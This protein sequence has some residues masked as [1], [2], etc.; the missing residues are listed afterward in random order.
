MPEQ[1]LR[2]A[3]AMVKSLNVPYQ[4][5]ET[6][7]LELDNFRE[8]SPDRCFHCKNEL[9]GKLR[10]IAESE[11]YGS[12]ADGTNLD[13]LDDRRP[14]RRAAI[15][16]GVRSPLAEAALRKADIRELS[17][18]LSLPTWD[19]P[20][21]PCLSSRFPFGE[22]ITIDALKRVQAAENVLRSLG[23]KELRVRHCGD[24]ARIELGENDI[25][26]I[27]QSELRTS[28]VEKLVEIGYKFV[29][30]DLEGFRSGKLNRA[31]K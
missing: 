27:L 14:G 20:S 22:P 17:R 30:L 3:K 9:F 16:Y 28:V 13:D 8:N 19:K 5:I 6:S 1:D 11:G 10:G 12:I 2:D 24:T 21:S 15:R 29:S 25:P 7:E 31:I 26:R 4:V 23:F 18:E